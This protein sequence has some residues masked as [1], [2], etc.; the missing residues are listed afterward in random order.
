MR[1]CS[2]GAAAAVW[3]DRLPLCSAPPA[4]PPPTHCPPT[5]SEEHSLAFPWHEGDF[6]PYADNGDSYWTG[7]YST[8]PAIKSASRDAE[9]W[10]RSAELLVGAARAARASGAGLAPDTD[11]LAA[12]RALEQVRGGAFIRLSRTP[13]HPP[14]PPPPNPPGPTGIRAAA[15]P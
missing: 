8:R 15:A 10:L 2:D 12:F 1:G 3:L 9:A 4:P 6:F 13:P 14:T 5:E 7:Y 11:W